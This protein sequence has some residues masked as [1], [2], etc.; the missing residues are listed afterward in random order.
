MDDPRVQWLQKYVCRGLAVSG[1][2]FQALIE[3][4]DADKSLQERFMA[5]RNGS[6]FEIDSFFANPKGGGSLFFFVDASSGTKALQISTS[7]LPDAIVSD[8]T[9]ATTE[10][11]SL[12]V[13]ALLF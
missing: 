2:Q 13:A 4:K 12:F 11:V 5:E 9:D 6:Q 7:K 1:A 10:D 3:E 8:T